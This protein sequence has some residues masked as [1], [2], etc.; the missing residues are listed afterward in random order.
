MDYNSYNDGGFNSDAQYT[1]SNGMEGSQRSSQTRNTLSPVTIKQINDAT[2]PVPDG[3]FFANKVALNMVSFVG[4]V[5]KVDNQTSAITVTIEDG[6]GSVEVRKWVDEKLGTASETAELYQ[7]M[8]NK[9]VYTTGA[10]KEFQKKKS[11]Q[12]ANIREIT[13]HNELI[14]HLLYTISNH[15]NAEGLL[16]G[17]K[18]ESSSGLFVDNPSPV[19]D[20]SKLNNQDKILAIL[21]ENANSMLEGVPVKWISDTLNIPEIVVKET[22]V[23]LS[24]QGKVYQGYDDGA[25]LSV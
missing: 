7:S 25:Y 13:D 23:L 2:Q 10:L 17:T 22:C 4:V 5:R 21:R 3:E 6:T 24:E 11:V 18:P 12:H 1:D 19:G 9:Y 8:E 20:S 14:Y 16:T 15:A